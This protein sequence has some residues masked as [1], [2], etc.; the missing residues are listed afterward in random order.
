LDKL[1]FRALTDENV[2]MD[3]SDFAIDLS[4]DVKERTLTIPTT[5][6]A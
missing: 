1:A 4:I 6:S 3:R 5:G 2:G